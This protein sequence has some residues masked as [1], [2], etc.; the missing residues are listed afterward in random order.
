M[1][2]DLNIRVGCYGDA[3]AV[4]PNVDRLSIL[5][6]RFDQAVC[7][8]PQCNPSRA[9][10]LTGL[11]PDTTGVMDNETD[12]RQNLPNAVT[13]PQLFRQNDY[14]TARIGK[15]FHDGLDDKESWD[16]AIETRR[17]ELGQQGEQG[18]LFAGDPTW[19]KAEGGDDD[20]PDGQ[21]ATNAIRLLEA[22][23]TQPFFLAVG[24]KNPHTPYFAPKKY[25]DLVDANQLVLPKAPVGDQADIPAAALDTVNTVHP[26]DDIWRNDLWGYYVATAFA[27]A[28]LGRVIAKLEELCLAQQTIV[29]F[30]S[31]HGIHNGEHYIWGKQTL[32]EESTRMPLI[33]CAPDA[34]ANGL[35][36]L[37]G[38]EEVDVYQTVA[39][40]C[41]LKQ[42]AGLE[43]LSFRRLLDN[44][45]LPWKTGTFSQVDHAGVMGR[46]VRT[47]RYRYTEWGDNGEEGMELYDHATDPHEFTNLATNPIY[48]LLRRSLQT[49]L[50]G[51]WQ[52]ALPK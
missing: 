2:D 14:Y 28:M 3:A 44:P 37:R 27:D 19:I 47:S 17:T 25:F 6:V 26:N 20:Q 43:G 16:K 36:C 4:T 1:M 18:P 32:F 8:Y 10:M 49:L 42:P 48:L 5:G 50:H 51:G 15:I 12:F 41:R 45:S 21:A 33:V 11:R 39:D 7:Q 46:S 23:Q 38:V 29:V 22:Y 24:F 52:T 34:R 30:V 31:D 9:S 13:L 35:P 40:L